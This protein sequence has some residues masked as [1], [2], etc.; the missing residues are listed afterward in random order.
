V[1][2]SIASSLT[3][4]HG[5]SAYLVVAAVV[6]AESGLIIGFVFPGEIAVIIGG[7]LANLHH[8]NLVIMLLVA[9]AAAIGAFAI[10]YGVGQLVG[11]WLL[12]HKPLKGWPAVT[13]AENLIQRY[14]GPAVLIG[15]FLA[16]ARALLPALVG[17]SEVPFPTF[18]LYNV[19]GGVAWATMFTFVGYAVGSSYEHLL[20]TI[21]D[22]TYVALGLVVVAWV[23]NHLRVRRRRAAGGPQGPSAERS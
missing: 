17:V 6:V 18:M 19:I 13:R 22:W 23:L 5:V 16:V 10:G 20:T 21:G 11:P 9:N 3:H 7:V 8:V 1:L 15:R 12:D 14:G 2:A 4:F